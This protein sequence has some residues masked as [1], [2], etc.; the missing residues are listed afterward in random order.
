MPTKQKTPIDTQRAY[1]DRTRVLYAE[2]R[3]L[4]AEWSNMDDSEMLSERSKEIETRLE[5]IQQAL[6]G[7]A[8]VLAD[9]L[10]THIEDMNS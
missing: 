2:Q 6:A 8:I 3:K 4:T 1:I 10:A 7:Q 9:M 5:H